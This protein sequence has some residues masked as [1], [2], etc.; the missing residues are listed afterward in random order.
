MSNFTLSRGR[1]QER[2]TIALLAFL[3]KLNFRLD[4]FHLSKPCLMR[5]IRDII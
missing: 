3:A 4:A 2:M 5:V 1:I